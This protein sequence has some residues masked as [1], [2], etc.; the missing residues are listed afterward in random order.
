MIKL[1]VENYCHAC[2]EFSPEVDMV[3]ADDDCS[4]TFVTCRWDEHCKYIRST[5]CR[6]IMDKISKKGSAE[7]S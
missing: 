5:V 4:T 3:F 1:D 7:E 6:N 2:R